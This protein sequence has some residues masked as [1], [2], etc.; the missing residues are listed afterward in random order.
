MIAAALSGL[1]GEAQRRHFDIGRAALAPD[2][3]GV[4]ERHAIGIGAAL[5]EEVEARR[6]RPRA[7]G[8]ARRGGSV[9]R[10]AT[11]GTRAD[12]SATGACAA[13]SGSARAADGGARRAHRELHLV[14]AEAIGRL[15]E[16]ADRERAHRANPRLAERAERTP[17]ETER[18]PQPEEE[19]DRAQ[20]AGALRTGRADGRG[21]FQEVGR[22][23]PRR[24]RSG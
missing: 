8:T 22:R 20:R 19:P 13:R 1:P 10:P 15:A 12:G 17:A 16:V 9:P 11:S 24:T 14:R 2:D 21:E 4:V 23:S 5:D 7:R 6:R 18:R 3:G